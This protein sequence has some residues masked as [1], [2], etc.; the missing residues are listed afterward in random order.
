M[1]IGA[2]W[3]GRNTVNVEIQVGSIPIISA[4]TVGSFMSLD[5]ITSNPGTD[6]HL[7]SSSCLTY[8]FPFISIYAVTVGR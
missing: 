2:A 7:R 6:A 1:D 3:C 5:H 4:N 8:L